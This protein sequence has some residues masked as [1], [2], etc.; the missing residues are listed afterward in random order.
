M[1]FVV[2]LAAGVLVLGR[3]A[4]AGSASTSSRA[5]PQ[6]ECAATLSAVCG[7][8]DWAAAPACKTCTALNWGALHGPAAAGCTNGTIEAH[9]AGL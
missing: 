5:D 8:R 4:A 2:L 9:C 6:P 3:P 7:R 1:P